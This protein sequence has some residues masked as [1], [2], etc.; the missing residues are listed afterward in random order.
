MLGM[1]EGAVNETALGDAA[2]RRVRHDSAASEYDRSF[3]QS[4]CEN[5]VAHGDH[6]GVAGLASLANPGSKR[7]RAG[8]AQIDQVDVRLVRGERLVQ[9]R[10]MVVQMR[11]LERERSMRIAEPRD[12]ARVGGEQ[13]RRTKQQRR[14][15]GSAGSHHGDRLTGYDREIDVAECLRRG[16]TG[17]APRDESLGD[18]RDFERRPHADR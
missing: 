6:D 5:R 16:Q 15:S 7:G 14:L 9:R 1:S 2:R 10:P 17:S 13:S 11:P 12:D 4:R 8:V 18:P 3:R